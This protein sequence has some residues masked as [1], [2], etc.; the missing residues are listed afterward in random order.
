[1]EKP[2]IEIGQ[3]VVF[4]PKESEANNYSKY[5]CDLGKRRTGLL[6]GEII[7]KGLRWKSVKLNDEIKLIRVEL[8]MIKDHKEGNLWVIQADRVL[9]I[10]NYTMEV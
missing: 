4:V 5:L 9:S 6:S 3:K 1:M 8:L 7:E 10:D 2:V